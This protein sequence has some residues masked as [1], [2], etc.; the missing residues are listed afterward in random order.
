MTSA[1]AAELRRQATPIA[2]A[3]NAL[4]SATGYRF[5][6]HSQAGRFRIQKSVYLLKHLGYRP[7]GRYSFNIYHMGPYSPALARAYYGLRDEGIREV[8]EAKNVPQDTLR[9][10]NDAL[11]KPND[12]LEAMTT[13]LDIWTRSRN[14]PAALSQAS[15]V[16]PHLSESNWK[17]VQ[18]FL[19]AHPAL[20]TTT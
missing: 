4:S 6:M 13:L 12:F 2:Q 11:S 1:E 14:L 15:S 19:T 20:T 18:R 9:L 17:E 7:A 3:L 16:K 10:L 8:G 5:S